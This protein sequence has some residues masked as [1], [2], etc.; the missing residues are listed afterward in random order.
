MAFVVAVYLVAVGLSEVYLAGIRD[1]AI[2][3]LVLVIEVRLFLRVR[4]INET[5]EYD[6]SDNNRL[7]L[8]SLSIPVT[9]FLG[10]FYFWSHSDYLILMLIAATAVFPFFIPF[11]HR[12]FTHLFALPR[13]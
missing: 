9:L 13:S 11:I 2:I 3:V 10:I 1:I 8:F 7:V 12:R 5:A 4:P 6:K